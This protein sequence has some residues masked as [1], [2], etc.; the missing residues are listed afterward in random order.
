MANLGYLYITELIILFSFLFLISYRAG[1]ANI[2]PLVL[3]QIA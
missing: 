2:I 3:N 1:Y